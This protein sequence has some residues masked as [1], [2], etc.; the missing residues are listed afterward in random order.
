MSR[1]ERLLQ[2]MEHLRA[3]RYPVS[4]AALAATLG[5]SLR[6]LYRDIA[7][8]QAQGAQ[9]EGEAGVG[10]VLKPGFTLPP[11]MFSEEEIEA[12]VLGI[13]F[14]AGHSDSALR[15]AGAQVLVKLS[16]VLPENL[17][18]EL[19]TSGL[20]VFP[21]E[22][23]HLTPDDYSILLR[24]AIRAEKKLAIHYLD[25][26]GK[27]SQRVIWPFSIG[28]F[29]EVRVLAAWCELRKEIRHFRTDRISHIDALNERYPQRRQAL[30]KIW[31]AQQGIDEAGL[32]AC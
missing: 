13:R 17:R 29:K 26:S 19:E 25:L 20:L 18:R 32:E 27:T 9:I 14:I 21:F 30:L 23:P 31:Q 10:Y 8:L 24:R 5:I 4:G 28:F 16:A 11:L 1:A 12:L 7:S 2:L 6:T 15:Q 22:S 3:H